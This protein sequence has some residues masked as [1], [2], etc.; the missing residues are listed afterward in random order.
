MYQYTL[1]SICY[2]ISDYNIT[3]GR[4]YITILRKYTTIFS[5]RIFRYVKI[6][7]VE[8]SVFYYTEAL[9]LRCSNN[10]A[11]FTEKHL[12]WSLLNKKETPTHAFSCKFRKISKNTFS[13]NNSGGCFCNYTFLIM[14][15]CSKLTAEKQGKICWLVAQSSGGQFR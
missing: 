6:C 8:R 11:N 4:K 15:S 10:F 5:M 7:T 2:V 1:S 14:K 13:N 12:C 9:V 3:L